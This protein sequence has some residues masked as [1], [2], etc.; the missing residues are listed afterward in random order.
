M[1]YDV[2]IV[3][4]GFSGCMVL[5]NMVRLATHPMRVALIDASGHAPLGPAYSTMR[6]E[7]LLNV[8][9]E[10]MGAFA[11]DPGAFY[12][13]LRTRSESL[14]PTDFAPRMLYGEYLRRVFENALSEAKTKNISVTQINASVTDIIPGA[15]FTLKTDK[16]SL[17]ANAVV[18]CP[19]N[20]FSGFAAPSARYITNVWAFA[21]LPAQTDLP[22]IL[23]GTGLTAV[24]VLAS[25][26]REGWTGNI[27]ALS[28]HGKF[29]MPHCEI[30]TPDW[31]KEAWD[32]LQT[33]LR[34][35]QL[36]QVIRQQIRLAA[37]QNVPWQKVMDSLRPG[38]SRL[39]Q[40]LPVSD[41]KRVFSRYISLWNIYRHRMPVAAERM[42][43]AIQKRSQLRVQT[44][45]VLS[46]EERVDC[47]AVRVA[48]RGQGAMLKGALVFDCTGPRQTLPPLLKNLVEAGRALYHPSGVGL[49]VDEAMRVSDHLYAIGSVAV[50][51]L[52]ESTAVPNLREQALMVAK[53]L[54]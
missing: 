24:D 48:E 20:Y 5:A 54:I 21:P 44:G 47:I 22:I 18:L 37:A 1:A 2:A 7:H 50:G 52:L 32:A 46:V 41:Q 38:T 13:W 6:S 19:G 36:M 4:S 31:P 15:P 14:G 53:S 51:T 23:I 43:D 26:S 30:P 45:K 12:V 39:W 40:A 8:P 29:P 49:V 42:I 11:D 25:L 3:G 16:E 34:L 27:L 33:P 17:M 9:A 28:R 10:R 35:S